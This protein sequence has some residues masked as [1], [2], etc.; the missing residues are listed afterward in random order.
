M[1]MRGNSIKLV[2]E[3]MDRNQMQENKARWTLFEQVSSTQS[4]VIWAIVAVVVVAA[5]YYLLM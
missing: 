1:S 2:E 4:A 5:A 3:P